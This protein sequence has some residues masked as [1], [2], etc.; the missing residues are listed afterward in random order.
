MKLRWNL[1]SVYSSW[2]I[3]WRWPVLIISVLIAIIAASGIR[4]FNFTADYRVYFSPEDPQL[5]AYNELE[6]TYTSTENLIFVLQPKEGDIFTR[7]TLGIVQKLTEDVWQ[8]PHVSQVNSITNFQHTEAKDDMLTMDDLV[9]DAESLSPADLDRIKHVALNELPLVKRLISEDARTAGVLVTFNFPGEDHTLHLPESVAYA[10][11]MLAKLRAEYPEITFALTGIAGM[12]Y[13]I[14]QASEVDLKT[15]VPFMYLC[16]IILMLL[17]LRSV[18]ATV[19]TLF[20]VTLSVITAVGIGLWLGVKLTPAS[21]IAPIVILT[22]AIADCVHIL[23]TTTNEMQQGRSKHEAL[24][25][26]LRINTEPVFLTSLT[27][28]IGFL[29]LNFSDSPPFRDLGNIAAIGVIAAWLF[30]M[31]ALPALI[32]ILPLRVKAQPEARAL[33]MQRFGDFVVRKRKSLLYS[34]SGLI[35]ILMSFIPSIEL[36]DQF[37]EYFSYSIPFRADTEFAAKH[38]VGPYQME[39]SLSSGESDG[40]SNPEYLKNIEAFAVWLRTQ[41]EVTHVNSYTDILKRIN[42]SMHNDDPAWYRLPDTVNLA[43]QY[44]FFYEISVPERHDFISQISSDQSATRLT[45]TTQNLTSNQIREFKQRAESWLADHAPP[46]MLTEGTGSTVM[47]AYFT[48]RNI[49]SMLKG[50]ALAFLLIG[51]TLIIA[52]RNFQLGLVSLVSN[53]FPVAITFGVWALFVG[54]MGII[55]SV[56]TATSLGLIV[57]DTVHILSKYNRA[58]HEHCMNTHNAIRY[59]FSHV[60]KALWVTTVILA[61]GFAILSFSSFK[62]NADMGILTAITLIFALMVDFL[63][64]PPLLMRLDHEDKCNCKSCSCEPC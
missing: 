4:F 63:L 53:F 43:A 60:G 36:N 40:I 51:L 50:T 16:I 59:T 17:L 3:R 45:V 13:A 9:E 55:A 27:T 2:V 14:T 11:Q 23:I 24:I 35:L 19:A 18:S 48:D 62:I 29:S 47:F 32:S 33:P 37:V 26:S 61:V 42:R 44:L 31:T 12:S 39:F 52:L 25:E 21:T 46:T 57:D 30:S 1:F 7:E 56:I 41:P 28:M 5:I 6:Y 49:R 10:E 54:E 64:L 38:L 58:K 20:V 34:M 22:L 15:L 8:I